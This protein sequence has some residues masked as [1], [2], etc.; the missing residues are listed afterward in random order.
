[1]TER[2]PAAEIVDAL[3]DGLA[4]HVRDLEQAETQRA[5]FAFDERPRAMA[6]STTRDGRHH[7][8]AALA[9]A[10][11]PIAIRVLVRL[12]N[13]P[14]SPADLMDVVSE[15]SDA[16]ATADVVAGLAAAGLVARELSADQVGLTPLGEAVVELVEELTDRLER[17]ATLDA[18]AMGVDR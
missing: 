16:I 12:R 13:G 1:M 3:A 7:V 11:H 2:R 17:A 10:G 5:A 15:R 18:A 14:V 6:A 9:A 4:A 8:A